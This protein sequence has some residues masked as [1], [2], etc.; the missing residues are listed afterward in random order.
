MD[1][2][3]HIAQIHG[4]LSYHGRLCPE[5]VWIELAEKA[6]RPIIFSLVYSNGE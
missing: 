2:V 4:I 6:E 3:E 5:D 1:L